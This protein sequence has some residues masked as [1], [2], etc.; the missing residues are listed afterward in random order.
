MHMFHI[1]QCSIQN[2]NVHI[3]V[4]N[5]ALWDMEQVHSG[6]CE[7]VWFITFISRTWQ[8]LIQYLWV[9]DVP[10]LFG[11]LYQMFTKLMALCKIAVSPVRQLW[12]YCSVVLCHQHVLKS[13]E[14]CFIW[15]TCDQRWSLSLLM[16]SPIYQVRH[17]LGFYILDDEVVLLADLT[18]PATEQ[19]QPLDIH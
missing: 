1:P 17:H 11:S 2:R 3:S 8:T 6:I 10:N 5:G 15:E 16:W 4:L 7:L 14:R 13:W 9:C 19:L 12:R 18:P